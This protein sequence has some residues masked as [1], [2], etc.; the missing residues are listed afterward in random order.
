MTIA[1]RSEALKAGLLAATLL[2]GIAFS[3]AADAQNRNCRNTGNFSRW[4]ADF[5]AEAVSAGISSRTIASALNGLKFAPEIV[6]KDRRQG[7]FSQSF[8]QFSGRMVAQNRLNIGRKKLRSLARTFAAIKKK[9][10]VPGPVLAAFWGLETD[11]G[12]NIG[13]E[14]TIRSIATLAFD[15]RRPELFRPQLMDALRIIERGD[16]TAR[17]MVGAWAGELGQT[18]FMAS[19]YFRRAVD[20]DGDGRVDLLRS[21]PDALASSAALLASYGWRRGEPWV[22]EVR[23]PRDMNWAK[24]DLGIKHPRSAWAKAGVFRANGKPLARGNAPAAL[25][26]PMG[27]N[28]PAFLA[29]RNFDIY[30]KWNQSYTYALTAAY[31]ATRLAG[32]PKVRKGNAAVQHLSGGQIKE[33]QRRLI[34]LGHDVGGADGTIG[35][36]T[37][38]AVKAV[39]LKLGL[40]ADS[41]PTPKLLQALR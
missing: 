17:Q 28:G 30:L 33:L 21:A 16:L 8:L 23:V 2:G 9:Y 20:F 12:A 36:K 37:R 27:R 32:A 39:Q 22:E 29:Y 5:K 26:L 24:A 25:L 10:G 35:R 11:F 31:F 6:R 7:V 4:L 40:P 13:N 18:Q 38:A 19:E 41:Y 14:P 3:T 34:G 1:L 15:C